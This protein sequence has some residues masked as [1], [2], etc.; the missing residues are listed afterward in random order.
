VVTDF[1]LMYYNARWYDPALGRFAQ[2]DTIGPD[3]VQGYDRYAYV[4]SN[5]VNYADPS[6][7]FGNRREEKSDYWNRAN[8]GRVRNLEQRWG[9]Q[10]ELRSSLEAW[11]RALSFAKMEMLTAATV[12]MGVGTQL[13][14]GS[15]LLVAGGGRLD[16]PCMG[17]D[18]VGMGGRFP[19]DPDAFLW[20]AGLSG[21]EPGLYNTAGMEKLLMLSDWRR[22]TFVYGGQGSSFGAGA[23]AAAY[24]G[25]VLNLAALENYKGPFGS[26]GVTA[27]IGDV[28]VTAFYFWG[29]SRPPFPAR[30][31]Q[32]LAVG[33]APAAQL[34]AW[35]S[36]TVYSLT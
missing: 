2:A 22:G 9:D 3:G 8:L 6:G 10:E 12:G 35:W 33:C 17:Q 36:S 20:G 5:P 31:T 11:R 15:A 34:S 30:T 1:G 24:A 4:G 18:G 13:G 32:G 25:V 7:H 28:G 27:S 14:S 29:N 21:T 26:A 23:S 16:G 19:Y